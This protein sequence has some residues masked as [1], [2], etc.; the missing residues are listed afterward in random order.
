MAGTVPQ[1]LQIELFNPTFGSG[2]PG[3]NVR[4]DQIYFDTSTNPYTGYIWDPNTMAWITV[5]ASIAGT[6]GSGNVVL[7]TSP[8]LLGNPT[9][10][11]QTTSDNSTKIASTAFVQSVAAGINPAVAVSAATTQAS[12]TSGMTYN[13]GTSGVGATM[14]GSV[15][16]AVTI[17]G[18][19]FTATGQRLLI[20]NDTQSPSGAYNGVYTLTR[21][22]TALL[23]PVFTRATDYNTPSDINYTGI[24]PVI[25][26][27][28]NGSTTWVIT[29]QVTTIGTDALAYTKFSKN[30]S[31]IVTAASSLAAGQPVTGD[32][33]AQGVKTGVKVGLAYGGT[34]A[35]LSATGG[36]SQYLKQAS[37]GAAI[38]VGQPAT[39]DLSDCT[40]GTFTPVLTFGGGNT[41]MTGSF[42]GVYRKIGNL[43]WVGIQIVL[44]NKG[45]S[46]GS[47]IITGLPFK[48]ISSSSNPP[49][50]VQTNNMLS[51]IANVTAEVNSNS[52]TMTPYKY[53]SGAIIQLANTDF[54]A[55]SEMD[56]SGLYAV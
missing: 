34:N 28:A 25:N 6:T 44:T 41:G 53:A 17:D 52:T 18:F 32:D 30:P 2:A 31:T 14:T 46:T 24:I 22:Q 1:I 48:S 9:T 47:A 42:N 16:T 37:A 12:D 11:T 54:T 35:D 38:T 49:A 40:S 15:N 19:T 8:S 29:S 10:P 50:A 20:K 23:A 36:T 27:T 7:Q 4:T 26:G 43:V 13:N 33:G 45:S 56:I 51:T 3:A 39:A 21:L 55:S 5:F